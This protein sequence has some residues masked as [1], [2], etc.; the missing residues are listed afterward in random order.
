MRLCCSGGASEVGIGEKEVASASTR[1]N[2]KPCFRVSAW[3]THGLYY[4]CSTRAKNGI[5]MGH[6]MLL[7]PSSLR[8]Q[9]DRAQNK[10]NFCSV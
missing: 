2:T 5:R 1:L 4:G 9:S 6:A 7:S 3:P 8:L 10:E